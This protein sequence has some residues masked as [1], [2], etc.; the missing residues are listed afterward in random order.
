MYGR[1]TCHV[2]AGEGSALAHVELVIAHRPITKKMPRSGNSSPFSNLSELL[3]VIAIHVVENARL[4]SR[5]SLRPR[6][7]IGANSV[8]ASRQLR[9]SL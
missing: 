1:L 6:L 4:A 8:S 3:L 9:F 5:G 2:R 7:I